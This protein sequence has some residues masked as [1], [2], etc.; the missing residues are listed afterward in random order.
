MKIALA[1]ALA[2][3]GTAVLAPIAAQAVDVE[4]TRIEM[5]ISEGQPA[6]GEL[7]LSNRGHKPVEIRL[8]AGPYRFLDPK[9]KLPS[10]QDWFHFEPDRLTLAAGASTSVRYTVTPPSNLDVDTAGEYLAAVLVDQLPAESEK[11]SEGTARL[12]VVPRIALATYLLVEGRDRI[13]VEMEKVTVSRSPNLLKMEV[14]LKNN[15]TVHVRPS[16]T[17]ALFQE[18]NHRVRT[19]ALGKSMPLLPTAHMTIPCF[20]PMPPAGRYRLV[21][22]VE[23]R[24]GTVLQKET[25]FEITPEKNVKQEQNR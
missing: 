3:F 16:G 5:K 24:E 18:D 19:V 22:T 6:E 23:V 15:G 2:L 25:H 8:S 21:S 9:L 7:R 12:T 13:E 4:P 17:I 11:T 10:C 14:S 1:P 20:L